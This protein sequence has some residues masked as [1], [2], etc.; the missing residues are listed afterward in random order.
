MRAYGMPMG[1]YELQ[2]LTGLQIT[3]A[4]RK[5]QIRDENQRYVDIADQICE[6]G[7]LGQRTGMG[8]YAYKDGNRAPIR[9][10]I[11]E[12]L[13]IAYSA[14]NGITRQ[15]F[16]AEQISER[17]L[18]VLAREGAAIVADGIAERNADVDM[19]QING[20][21]FPRWRGGPMH[22]AETTGLIR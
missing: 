7:R 1:P 6:L 11:V 12:S 9:D 20:Y 2:D 14:T 18:A 19:V 8:W 17:L 15:K 10:E 13:I 21:G 22:Y 3:W 5:R 16:T 4:N